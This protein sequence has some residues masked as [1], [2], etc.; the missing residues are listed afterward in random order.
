MH[1]DGRGKVLSETGFRHRT[2]HI[3][4]NVHLKVRIMIVIRSKRTKTKRKLCRRKLTMNKSPK[5]PRTA[6]IKSHRKRDES[7]SRQ[8]KHLQKSVSRDCSFENNKRGIFFRK[9]VSKA[10]ISFGETNSGM[11][12]INFVFDADTGSE[13][14][15]EDLVEPC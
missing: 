1:E 13:M 14:L 5:L 7:I 6:K 12:P 8:L 4:S 3:D 2:A 9:I 11:H 15:Q 10:D